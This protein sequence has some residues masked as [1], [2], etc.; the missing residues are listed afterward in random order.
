MSINTR[1]IICVVCVFL[2]RIYWCIAFCG[3]CSPVD[4]SYNYVNK[5]FRARV[6][7]IVSKVYFKTWH[8]RDFLHS[9]E[10][11]PILNSV[12]KR[13][14]RWLTYDMQLILRISAFLALFQLKITPASLQNLKNHR[15]LVHF[16]SANNFPN[17]NRTCVMC[18]IVIG[19][20]SD[21]L[22]PI[23][24]GKSFNC[25]KKGSFLSYSGL[26]NFHS[27][28]SQLISLLLW[29]IDFLIRSILLSA[30]NKININSYISAKV[31]AIFSKIAAI[32]RMCW[33]FFVKLD[34]FFKIFINLK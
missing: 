6:C 20:I 19:N 33:L 29:G 13:V 9:N 8:T 28:L 30:A 31:K 23:F 15:D 32:W 5:K 2:T 22:A 14:K 16:E 26:H 7:A 25:I 3:V 27:C 4:I 1:I 10:N 12:T 17:D 11:A 21:T 18:C 24:C 34:S